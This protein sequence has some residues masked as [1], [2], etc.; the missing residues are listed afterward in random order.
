MKLPR[1]RDG[2]DVICTGDTKRA[3][4]PKAAG[5]ERISLSSDRLWQSVFLLWPA[6]LCKGSIRL[7]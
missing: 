5:V 6:L 1:Y 7:L 3:G 2:D 4:V